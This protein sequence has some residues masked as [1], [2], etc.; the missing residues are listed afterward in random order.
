MPPTNLADVLNAAVELLEDVYINGRGI[1]D[2]TVLWG[3]GVPYMLHEML[4]CFPLERLTVDRNA[5][6]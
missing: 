5:A 1:A 3:N 6:R 2:P 4:D